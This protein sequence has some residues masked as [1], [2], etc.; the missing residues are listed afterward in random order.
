MRIIGVDPG[1]S[2]TGFGIIDQHP[3]PSYVAAGAIRIADTM[4]GGVRLAEIYGRLLAL[5]DQYAPTAMSLERS[6]VAVN[7]QSAFR[8]GEAR[9]VAMLAA[10][11][12][13]LA[14]FEY[15]PTDVKLTVAGYGRA[16]KAQVSAMVRRTL[17]LEG[18]AALPHDATDALALALC[19][20]FRARFSGAVSTDSTRPNARVRR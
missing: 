19:H 10:A 9:A 5:I 4:R 11:H 18:G 15:S 7:I 1:S 6:F 13:D 17:G 8:L 14:L 12:C 20:V 16:D 2:V 3:A